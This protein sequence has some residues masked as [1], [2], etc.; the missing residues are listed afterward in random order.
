MISWINQSIFL[1]EQLNLLVKQMTREWT[2]LILSQSLPLEVSDE[3][4]TSDQLIWKFEL[5]NL[6]IIYNNQ[7]VSS[8]NFHL[9]QSVLTKAM[10]MVWLQ[11]LIAAVGLRFFINVLLL[12]YFF[13]VLWLLADSY[14]GSTLRTDDLHISISGLLPLSLLPRI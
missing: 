5:S 9:W 6:F 11:L 14:D 8:Y 13:I 4:Q 10:L 1:W 3:K 12:S 2:E 7:K